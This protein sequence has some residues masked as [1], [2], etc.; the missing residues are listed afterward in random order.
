MIFADFNEIVGDQ[1]HYDADMKIIDELIDALMDEKTSERL[2]SWK[3]KMQENEVAKSRW[4]LQDEV[5]PVFK[6][7]RNQVD[8]QS[9]LEE[10]SQPWR[11]LWGPALGAIPELSNIAPYLQWVPPAGFNGAQNWKVSGE[12][13]MK[14]VAAMGISSAGLDQWRPDQ[15]RLLPS[16]F[17]MIAACFANTVPEQNLPMPHTWHHVKVALIPKDGS[18]DLRPISVS[19]AMWRIVMSATLG[20]VDSWIQSWA[21]PSLHSG[22]RGRSASDLHH[23]FGKDLLKAT[24]GKKSLAVRSIS[25]NVLTVSVRPWPSMSWISSVHQRKLRG[26]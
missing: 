19:V 24:T 6:E 1:F 13:L 15:L 5:L 9:L 2:E 17:W 11:V 7:P 16:G 12:Q 21:H 25:A 20:N 26:V 14:K 23:S 10:R 22:I 18:D 8:P 4:I 3:N